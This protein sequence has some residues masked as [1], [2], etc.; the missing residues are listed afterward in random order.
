MGKNLERLEAYAKASNMQL[1]AKFR[2]RAH[3]GPAP[4]TA[5]AVGVGALLLAGAGIV[6]INSQVGAPRVPAIA[7]AQKVI[8]RF[9]SSGI[10]ATA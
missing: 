8:Q 1:P 5:V 10:P 2:V 6:Y 7:K 3:R 9:N 4:T